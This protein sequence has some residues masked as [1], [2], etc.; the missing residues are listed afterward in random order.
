MSKILNI[1]NESYEIGDSFTAWEFSNH[2]R[3]DYKVCCMVLRKLHN[4]FK[5]GAHRSNL[6]EMYYYRFSEEDRIEAIEK[7]NETIIKY[8]L[9]QKLILIKK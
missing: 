2:S 1:I 8:N 9:K 6:N 4:N 3:I 7:Y 5:I